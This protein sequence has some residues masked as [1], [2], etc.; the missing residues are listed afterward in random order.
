MISDIKNHLEIVIVTYKRAILLQKT[1]AALCE[2]PFAQCRITVLNNASTDNTLEVCNSYRD[3][4]SN[5]FVI[6]HKANIGGN[7]NILRAIETS[8]GKYTWVL[9]DDDEYG[10]S[11]CDDLLEAIIKEKSDLIHVGAHAD[12]SWDL[13]GSFDAPRELIKKGYSFFRFSSFLPCNIFK[14]KSFYPY[15]ISGYENI[16]NLYPHMPFLMSF[17]ELDKKIYITKNR[18]VRA[19][20]GNQEYSSRDFIMGWLN[21]SLLLSD[22]R[23]RI[24]MFRDQF[25]KKNDNN[26]FYF[27]LRSL[28]DMKRYKISVANHFRLFGVFGFSL[29]VILWPFY[30]FY[31]KTRKIYK[32]VKMLND[33]K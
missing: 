22:K 26:N 16:I 31:K 25:I 4:L 14:T 28:H 18:I 27:P 33:S 7:A 13:G 19:V 32:K 3:K 12:V 6:T 20:I 15:L 11:D 2:S 30:C 21:T 8:N 24:L 29:S 17:Y 23:D 9:A 1:I 5:L 10:F